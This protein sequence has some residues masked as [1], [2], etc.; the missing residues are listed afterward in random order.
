VAASVDVPVLIVGA[1]PVGLALAIELGMRGVR[2]IVVE[3]GDGTI[4]DAKM[5]ATGIRTVEFCRRWGVADRVRNWDFPRDFPFDNVWVTSLSGYEL[6][7]M[8]RPSIADTPPSRV[9]PEQY[10]HC[11]QFVF[12]PILVDKVR[13]LPSVDLRYRNQLLDFADRGALLEAR[14]RNHESGRDETLRASYLVGCDGFRSVV[15]KRLGIAMRGIPFIGHSV[16]I[17]FSTPNLA[18]YHD[19]GNAGRYVL[20]GPEG[21]WASLVAADGRHRWRL[22]LRGSENFD[23][24][25]VDAE[26]MVRRAMGR[27]FDFEILTV[28]RWTRRRMVADRYRKGLVFMAGDAVHVMPPNGGLGMNTGIGDAVDLGWKLAAVLTG[29]GGPRLL[30]SY[31]AER[32]PAGIQQCDEAIANARRAI[33]ATKHAAIEDDTQEAARLRG[34][35]GTHL[36]D[37]NRAAWDEPDA[38]HLGYRYDGSPIIAPDGTPP[39]AEPADRCHYDQTARPGARAPHAWL[40]DGRSTLDLFGRGFTLLRLGEHSPAADALAGAARARGVP[41]TEVRRKEPEIAALYGQPLVLVRP[42]GHVAWRGARVP[43]DPGRLADLVR[44]AASM[45]A[46]DGP[47]DV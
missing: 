9:S 31:E 39:P 42:D 35:L 46:G 40:R 6:G 1:G 33:D 19:K 41:L 16:N 34:R 37:A 28:T 44:G 43:A 4:I 25:N 2:A 15:R 5:F 21:N 20:I 30:E 3:Q 38:T 8:A 45:S 29:W 11:P 32:R 36:A 17:M 18:A 10:A 26:E 47:A 27:D 14:I 13:T 22:M 23:I 7:R 12:D 24:S